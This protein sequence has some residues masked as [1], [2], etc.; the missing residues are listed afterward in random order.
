MV[1]N[2]KSNRQREGKRSW[3]CTATRKKFIYSYYINH[4]PA[5]SPYRGAFVLPHLGEMK[6]ELMD[7][8]VAQRQRDRFGPAGHPQFGQDIA[9]VGFIV[10]ALTVS[11]PAICVLFSPSTIKARTSS[12]RS[13]RSSPRE[14]GWLVVSTSA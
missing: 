13:V 3:V 8:A 11:L 6:R 2:D 9:D 7:D 4:P 1:R 10:D 14:G 5:A 12:S